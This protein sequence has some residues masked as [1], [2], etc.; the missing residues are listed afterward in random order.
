[1][2]VDLCLTI[3]GLLAAIAAPRLLQGL[4]AAQR[5]PRLGVVAWLSAAA[6]VLASWL[7]AALSLAIHPQTIAQA[8][9][10]TLAAGL[11]GRLGWVSV[12][13]WWTT[14]S[15]RAQH[16]LAARMVGRHDPTLDAIVI[17]FPDPLAY[18]LPHAG[19]GL[20]VVS[21]GARSLLSTR[22]LQA[23][24]THERVHLAGHHHVLL[25]TVQSLSQVLPRL[26]LFRLLAPEVG[27]LLEMRADDVAARVHGRRT[28]ANAIAAMGTPA[29]PIASMGAGGPTAITR[30][31]RLIEHTKASQR[32]RVWLATVVIVLA[33]GPFLATL[34]PCP[35]PW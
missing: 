16:A 32:D 9:G 2:N 4:H 15:R 27:R 18:C 14:R 1:M 3:Y 23:V 30:V 19:G 25:T 10:A 13:T 22:Q 33:A 20:V 8:I 35:H 24:L 29:A 12:R 21:S 7:L 11:A 6:S 34:P 5:S 28:V 17:D 26:H 31:A